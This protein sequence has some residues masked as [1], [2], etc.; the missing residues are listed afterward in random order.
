MAKKKEAAFGAS[1]PCFAPGNYPNYSN[2]V[3]YSALVSAGRTTNNATGQKYADNSLQIDIN[4]F[5][6]AQITEAVM[7]LPQQEDA[8]ITGATYTGT[9][10]VRNKNDSPPW[11]GKG[12]IQALQDTDGN[13]FFRAFFYP[14]AKAALGDNTAQTKESS[15]TFNDVNL[16]WT[17]TDE[18]AAGD[19]VFEEEFT[20]EDAAQAYLNQKLGLAEHVLFTVAVNGADADETVSR[21]GRFYIPLGT[22]FSITITGTPTMLYDNGV[23]Q[24]TNISAE[25]VYTLAAVSAAHDIAVIF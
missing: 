22:D 6:N 25:G 18:P 8:L 19:W 15:A 1:Y 20:T 16:V 12:Y 4:Q 3:V 11:G 24:K 17:A 7:G 9:G 14:R 5:L 21:T 13:N 2:G 23:D 10:L